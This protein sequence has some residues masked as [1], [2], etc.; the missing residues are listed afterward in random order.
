MS[1]SF[2]L[3]PPALKISILREPKK[4]VRIVLGVLL[5]ANLVAAYFVIRP[6]GGS[7][8][9][10][11]RQIVSLRK[12]IAAKQQTTVKLKTVVAKVDT[13]RAE[14]DKFLGGYFIPRRSAYS[15]LA[16]E[17]GKAAQAAGVK[18]KEH[19]LSYELIEGS[20]TLGMLT[21]NANYEGTYADLIAFVNLLDRSDKLLIIDALQAQ[22]QQGSQM[23]T[24]GLKMN[25]FL[26][27]EAQP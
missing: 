11:E 15:T 10:Q 17:L 22:P 8:D 14:G 26:R 18:P 24:I 5:L 27:E 25:A 3:A 19:S 23:L 4:L 12:Q 9:D 1:K 2:K 7:L 6:L 21:I 20:D 13:A 16:I